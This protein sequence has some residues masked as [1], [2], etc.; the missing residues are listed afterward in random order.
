[1]IS[2]QK[3]YPVHY[4]KVKIAHKNVRISYMQNNSRE[5]L[6][7]HQEDKTNAPGVIEYVHR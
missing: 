6:S 3:P 7:L 4:H 5:L 2:K 1:M